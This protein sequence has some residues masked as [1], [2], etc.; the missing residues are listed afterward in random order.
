MAVI[1][2]APSTT[3][4]AVEKLQESMVTAAP[5]VDP[6]MVQ[7]E[8]E[9]PVSPTS[10]SIFDRIAA[11]PVAEATQDNVEQQA[12]QVGEQV[13]EAV[14][15][16]SPVA[17]ELAAIATAELESN[18]KRLN[19]KQL[20]RAEAKK[21]IV[22]PLNE[23][24]KEDSGQWFYNAVIAEDAASDVTSGPMSDGGL[25]ARARNLSNGVYGGTASQ[26]QAEI[27]QNGKP[28]NGLFGIAGLTEAATN[29]VALNVLERL[30]AVDRN[31]G[32]P[33]RD[34]L[35][36]MSVVAEDTISQLSFSEPT[37]L[38]IN[39]G[40]TAINDDGEV[41][42]VTEEE[43][44][45]STPFSKA[46][47][48][49]DLGTRI[50]REFQRLRNKA[51]GRPTDEYQDI[52]ADEA[53][54]LGD[55]AKELYWAANKTVDGKNFLVRQKANDGQV[56]FTLTKHGSDMLKQGAARRKRMFPG[57]QV[58]TQKNSGV[59]LTGEA[60][61]A[62][63]K[64]SSRAGRLTG[65][66]ELNQAMANLNKVANVVDPRRL[67]IL[68]LTALPVLLGQAAPDTLYASL[69]HVGQDKLNKFLA[70]AAA[71]TG[72]P[73]EQET[74]NATQEYN[75]LINDLA[76]DLRGIAL[77][78]K[79]ANYLTYYVQA[80]NTRIAPQQST[81]DPTTSK[82]AR[83][84]TRNAKPSLVD[85][86]TGT[87]R[88]IER[89]LRQ[90]YAM[91]LVKGAGPKFP[92]ER[93]S[94]LEIATPQLVKWGISLRAALDGVP[95]SKIEE[96]SQ[97][98]EDGI[99]VNDPN[100]PQIPQLPSD[101]DP[102]L[103]E[104]IKK[105]GEDGQAYID[106][107]IDFANYYEVKTRAASDKLAGRSDG[108]YQF[109]SFFN[110]YM[111]GKTNGLASNGMQMGSMSVAQRTGVLRSQNTSAID[112]NEDI[113]DEL[114]NLLLASLDDGFDG[115]T[116]E[117]GDYLH[118]IATEVFSIRALNKATTMTFGYGKELNSFKRDIR[119]YLDLMEQEKAAEGSNYNEV[120]LAV[121]ALTSD[122]KDGRDALVEILH[123]KYVPS[124]VQ[125]LDKR[126]LQSRNIMRGAAM[127]HAL[128]NELF[129]I[130]SP[131]GTSLNLGGSATTGYIEGDAYKVWSD[132]KYSLRKVGRFGDELTAAAPR[133]M[134][135][136]SVPGERAYG[137][138]VPAP[139]QSLDAATVIR[140]A[141]GKSWSRLEAASGGAPY[142]HTIY[143]A[144]KV[145]AMGYDVV[146]E[147]VN[148]NWLDLNMQWSYLEKTSDALNNLRSKFAER[149][150]GRDP[151]DVL[152]ANE[153]SM[154]GYLLEQTKVEGKSIS[155]NLMNKLSKVLDLPVVDK[156]N[157]LIEKHPEVE[158]ATKRIE[159]AMI[160]A[161]YNPK[162]PP[163]QPT[164]R[165]IR[166]FV[167]AF[168]KELNMQ[169]RLNKMIA[170]TNRDKAVLK[171]EIEKQI[172]D[173]NFGVAQYMDH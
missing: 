134:D 161:G 94:M 135:D 66:Q 157:K 122:T 24:T 82:T 37:S 89:N 68:Y 60:E 40:E 57:K 159:D 17:P 172:S 128:S 67:K 12:E 76:Q 143:D 111:D 101:L 133:L 154:A 11:Q 114:A 92:A 34:F 158:E 98:I 104:T 78:R 85:S 124:L 9:A 54:A 167:Q 28:P 10:G 56:Y 42:N 31:A 142:L 132:G 148:Q 166:A 117:V 102:E 109:P 127:L 45:Q 1:R 3:Q 81:L 147:E 51:E 72:S 99:S 18:P 153:W 73:T 93:E 115:H 116:G 4:K 38:D 70:K 35:Q 105:Q 150:S 63:R 26:V 91:H 168:S 86:K 80:F 119:E 53:I 149:Y 27:E 173:G 144:F 156:N 8:G 49:R 50:S 21:N 165:H 123:A 130:E 170:E 64:V 22:K 106:G 47:A 41:Q 100:F 160:A 108:N 110:A 44:A 62:T 171:S 136:V 58:R 155:S 79:G 125:V 131:T 32:K 2:G 59:K 162:S 25:I 103:L 151:N 84:V 33:T 55:M 146:F 7:Q 77:E 46:K 61:K 140:T 121:E 48:N 141:S 20:E 75:D 65:T 29:N 152:K 16:G 112:N 36:T 6:K 118:N 88:R 139:V 95:D 13:Q 96:I 137:G 169:G 164:V 71:K 113:R 69:N 39:P 19:Q 97:A 163:A 107:L 30:N 129:T 87:G 126:A 43:I 5:E 83:F 15:E 138:S 74:A 52:S 145:D 14:V 23:R 120:A 90:M